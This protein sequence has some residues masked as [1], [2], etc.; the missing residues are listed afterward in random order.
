MTLISHQH[1]TLA[2][3]LARLYTSVSLGRSSVLA[4][5]QR[6]TTLPVAPSTSGITM[7]LPGSP[8]SIPQKDSPSPLLLSFSNMTFVDS[9]VWFR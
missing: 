6:S 2:L 1:R 3:L 5:S 4:G 9:I 8:L 7:T